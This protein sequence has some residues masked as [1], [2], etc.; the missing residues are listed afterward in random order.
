MT[1][2]ALCELIC[3]PPS[4]NALAVL[5][6]TI[7]HERLTLPQAALLWKR[8]VGVAALL[9]YCTPMNTAPPIAPHPPNP[10]ATPI[11]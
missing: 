3:L 4:E 5:E 11:A 2:A 7:D 10:V 1:H 8:I 9:D 6:H